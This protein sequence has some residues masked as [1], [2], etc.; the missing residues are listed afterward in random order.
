MKGR[1]TP[2]VLALLLATSGCLGFVTGQE[3]L[4]LEAEAA[5]VD[6]AAAEQAGYEFNGTRSM[7]VNRTVEA[8]GQSR[9][10]QATNEISTYEKA[11]K[12]PVVGT[13]K[14]GVFSLISTPAAEIAGRTLNPIGDYDNDRLVRMVESRYD[15]LS[16]VQR[17]SSRSITVLGSD[18]EVTKYSA[19]AS[20]AGQRV[21]VFVHVTKVRRGDDFVVALGVYPQRLSGEEGRILDLMRAADHPD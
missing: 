12:I 6:D 16:N 9:E 20:I 19:K 3:P 18:T 15:G 21:D 8:A 13:A 17:V 5:T 10:V 4:R 1:L 14:L 11:V 7:T 2:L